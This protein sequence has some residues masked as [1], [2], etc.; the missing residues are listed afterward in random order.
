[1]DFIDSHSLE[2]TNG[3]A[4]RISDRSVRFS[5]FSA[6][7][8]GVNSALLKRWEVPSAALDLQGGFRHELD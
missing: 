2:V 4:S 5:G 7:K 1:M 6:K 3:L 8:E